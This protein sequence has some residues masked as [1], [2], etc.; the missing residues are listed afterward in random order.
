SARGVPGRPPARVPPGWASAVVAA[1][2][3]GPRPAPNRTGEPFRRASAVRGDPACED[4]ACADAAGV[5]DWLDRPAPE[6]PESSSPGC[7]PATGAVACANHTP[8]AIRPA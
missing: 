5:A 8:P 4:P 2:P 1:V 7:A 3:I 6:S